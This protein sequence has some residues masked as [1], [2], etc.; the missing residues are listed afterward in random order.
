[1][2]QAIRWESG[3][4]WWR[5]QTWARG[6]V[7]YRLVKGCSGARGKSSLLVFHDQG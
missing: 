1:M 2:P 5:G 3:G 6:Q 4:E 7:L